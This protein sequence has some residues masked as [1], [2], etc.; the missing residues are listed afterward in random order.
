MCQVAEQRLVQEL[1]PHPAVEVFYKS[2]ADWLARRKVVRFDLVLGAPVQDRVRGKLRPIVADDHS[3]PAAAFDQGRQF[4][5]HAAARDRGI[6]DRRRT[7]PRD[8]IDNFQHEKAPPA[9]KL[10]MDEIQRPACFGPRLDQ[11]RGPFADGLWRLQMGNA[12]TR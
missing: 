2:V 7:F 1:V 5:G 12:S 11:D 6:E 8:V 9:G 3:R 10:V 4:T